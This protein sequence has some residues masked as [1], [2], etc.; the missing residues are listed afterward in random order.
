HSAQKGDRKE[1]AVTVL[2]TIE[3]AF[4]WILRG[5]FYAA[6]LIIAVFILRL[7]LNNKLSPACWC[8]LWL[9]AGL[10]FVIPPA[11][12]VNTHL[13]HQ[14]APLSS[15]IKPPAQTSTLI[16][17]ITLFPPPTLTPAAEPPTSH[18]PVLFQRNVAL[19]WLA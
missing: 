15:D 11:F 8:A 7:I 2:H 14:P 1:T 18:S 3:S 12:S 19:A 10:R 16:T 17:R 4:A 9:V 13:Y 5:S 6:M